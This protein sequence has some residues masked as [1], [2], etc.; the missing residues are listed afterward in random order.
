[1]DSLFIKIDDLDVRFERKLYS[2]EESNYILYQLIHETKWSQDEVIVFNKKHK[3]PRL[4][5][6]H[7]NSGKSYTW[8]GNLMRPLPWTKLLLEIKSKVEFFS[9]A[10]YNSVLLNYYRNGNDGMGYHADDEQEL[11]ANPT[12][13]SLS[14]GQ[15]R[16]FHLKHKYNKEIPTQKLL[17][18]SGSLLVMSGTTQQYFKHAIPKTKKAIGPRV[19]LTFRKI[20]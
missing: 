16:P 17:L 15:E 6:W 10:N 9:K 14:F 19:N 13:A 1:M 2:T 3:I 7:G 5:A 18:Q 4:N 8:S 12:I 20:Y 11:G